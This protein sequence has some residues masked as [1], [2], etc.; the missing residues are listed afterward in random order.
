MNYHFLLHLQARTNL[1]CQ[2]LC[3]SWSKERMVIKQKNW[4]HKKQG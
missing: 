3:L 1:P 4:H 2:R